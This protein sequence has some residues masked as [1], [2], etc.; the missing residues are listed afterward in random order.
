MLTLLATTGL[1]IVVV[2]LAAIVVPY[3]G[4]SRDLITSWNI[5]LL[6]IANFVGI[7]T[8]QAARYWD[9]FQVSRFLSL[10]DEMIWRYLGSLALFFTTLVIVYSAPQFAFVNRLSIKKWPVETFSAL[11]LQCGLLIILSTFGPLISVRI[12]GV[13][14]FLGIVGQTAG[15]AAFVLVMIAWYRRPENVILLIATAAMLVFALIV[16]LSFGSSRRPLLSTVAAIPIVYY[17]I[18]GRGSNRVI[19]VTVLAICSFVALLAIGAYGNVRHNQDANLSPITRAVESIRALPAIMMSP[20]EV[21]S[22]GLLGGDA[23]PNSLAVTSIYPADLPMQPMSSAVFV[24]TNPMP[25]ALWPGKPE[26][27][28]QTLPRYLGQWRYGYINWGP[29][30]IGNFYADGGFFVMPIYAAILGL[31]MRWFDYQLTNDPE[32]PYLL[33]ILAAISGQWVAMP[34]GDV[35]VFSVQVIGAFIGILVVTRIALSACGRR[36]A[37][38]IPVASTGSAPTMYPSIR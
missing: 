18:R 32:N 23:V 33:A 22:I 37:P 25:R 12:Q 6:G 30:M 19:V 10:T 38:G 27:L 8:W 29:G 35:G 24:L 36:V 9:L 4:G 26:A 31:L 2:C 34:R 20:G 3:L 28:G 1:L 13:A 15:I 5:F 11:W 16:G 17:W 21:L 7:S 14:Q